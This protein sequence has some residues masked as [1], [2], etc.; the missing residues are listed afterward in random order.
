MSIGILADLAKP[1]LPTPVV[2]AA[3]DS[4][5]EDSIASDVA[6]LDSIAK[7]I[8]QS[9]DS[10]AHGV[11]V[12]ESLSSVVTNTL[13]IYGD[14]GMT[15]QS[16]ELM[17]LSVESVM[18]AAGI[19]IPAAMLVPSFESSQDYNTEAAEKSESIL[20]KIMKWV[21]AALKAI[22]DAI[23]AFWNRL[24][25]SADKTE[26]YVDKVK[27]KV[28]TV[29]GEI[30]DPK[31]V[32]NLG[33][34]SSWLIGRNDQIAA[35]DKHLVDTVARYEDFVHDWSG[36]FGKIIGYAFPSNLTSGQ[37]VETVATN[38]LSL[39]KA[40]TAGH[41]DVRLE[42]IVG[43]Y[44]EVKGGAGEVPIM[45]AT[46]KIVKGN[47]TKAQ[48]APVLT[49]PEM[50]HGISTAVAAVKVL[51]GMKA[52]IDTIGRCTEKVSKLAKSTTWPDASKEQQDRFKQA[53]KALSRACSICAWGWTNT[54][55][56]FI[57]T[58]NASVRYIDASANRYS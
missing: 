34:A 4:D 2:G 16:S 57:K 50:Q 17:R 22:A 28:D 12:S 53:M 58:V 33:S 56:Y 39:S 20:G 19:T 48:V 23:V 36:K 10:I 41:A 54:V 13:E 31:A 24:T 6:E 26:Q 43:H 7:A 11:C 49:I 52:N 44:L 40:A 45:T 38:M 8:E 46:T 42:F 30:H 18:M 29:K 51:K 15:Q 3:P 5:I 21:Q 55:P 35:P 37:S 9:S 1:H 14:D 32:I 27:A 25:V 47:P